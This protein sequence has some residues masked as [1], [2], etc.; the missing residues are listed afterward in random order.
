MSFNISINRNYLNF[1]LSF[2]LLS[3]ILIRSSVIRDFIPNIFFYLYVI[4][5]NFYLFSSEK[6][7]ISKS[8]IYLYLFCLISLI[9]SFSFGWINPFLNSWYRFFLFILTFNIIG[10][11]LNNS[12]S[13]LFRNV[14]YKSLFFSLPIIFLIDSFYILYFRRVTFGGHAEGFLE[15]PNLSG[16]IA[17]LNILMF[18]IY[19][20][21]DDKWMNKLFY[22]FFILLGIP[23]LLAS[24]SRAAILALLVCI[25]FL[26]LL[27]SRKISLLFILLRIQKE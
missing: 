3:I 4:L 22:L 16:V 21:R 1:F 13:L 7:K 6:I 15:S 23:I 25:L 10:P 8:S 2:I 12:S 9:F 5:L 19:F 20:L 17:A 11:F 27:N 24:A 14:L 26:F 18:L